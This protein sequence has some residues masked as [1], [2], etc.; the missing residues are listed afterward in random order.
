MFAHIYILIVLDLQRTNGEQGTQLL[1][2]AYSPVLAYMVFFYYF[3][4]INVVMLNL[5]IALMGT[6]NTSKS[7]KI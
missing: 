4:I 3:I 7:V 1:D 6:I 2:N 5:L